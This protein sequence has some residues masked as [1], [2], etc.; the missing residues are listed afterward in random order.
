[1][2]AR[3]FCVLELANER[4]K[5]FKRTEIEDGKQIWIL[6]SAADISHLLNENRDFC[7]L[8]Q[9][10]L[11]DIN[12]KFFSDISQCSFSEL[13]NR[14]LPNKLE[15]KINEKFLLKSQIDSLNEN[16]KLIEIEQNN[17]LGC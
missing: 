6:E 1:M 10:K 9:K 5:L 2:L 12:S 13:E 17:T 15:K 11:N 8:Q 16:I 4:K 3:H 14:C 7:E